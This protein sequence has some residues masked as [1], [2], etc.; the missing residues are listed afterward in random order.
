MKIIQRFI[1]IL[2]FLSFSMQEDHFYEIN[3]DLYTYLDLQGYEN[4]EEYIYILKNLSI[5]FENSYAFNDISKNPPQP[6][7][8]EDYHKRVNITNILNNIN[9]T[10][11][12]AYE[13]YRRIAIALSDLRDAHIQ[14]LFNEFEFKDFFLVS[15]F[16]FYIGEYN[17]QPKIFI[18]CDEAIVSEYSDPFINSMCEGYLSFPVKSINGKDPFDY[19]TD[20]GGHFVSTKNIHGTFSFKMRFH[21]TISLTDFLYDFQDEEMKKINIVLEDNGTEIETIETE[22]RL[23]TDIDIYDESQFLRALKN[24]RGFYTRDFFKKNK[25]KKT[26]NKNWSI[27]EEIKRKNK[28][29]KRNKNKNKNNKIFN[30]NKSKLRN[31]PT[32]WDVDTEIFKCREDNENYLNLYY[33]TSFEPEDRQEFIDSI[34]E[35]VRIFDENTY[36]IV[37]INELNNGGYVSLSQLFMGILSPLMPINLF[38][39][40]IRITESLQESEELINFISSN[41]TDINT[42]QNMTFEQLI[43]GQVT[44]DYSETNLSEVF[45][46]NNASIYRKIENLR[47]NMK[48]K[49][50]PTEILVLTDGYSFSAA[51]LY[52]KYLQKMGG[53]IVAGYYGNPFNRDV[54]DSSQSPSPVFTSK[55][56]N[57]FNPVENGYLFNNYSIELQVPGM[58]TFYELDDK[59]IPLEYDVTPVDYRIDIY[60]DL[61]YNY[62]DYEDHEKEAKIYEAFVNASI[63]IFS[64][65]NETSCDSNKKNIIKFSEECDIYFINSK[66]HGGYICGDDN[67]WSSECIEAFCDEGYIFDKNKKECIKDICSSYYD[68][69]DEEPEEEEE[70]DIDIEEEEEEE[71]EEINEEEESDIEEEEIREEGEEENEE[72]EIKGEEEMEGEEEKINEEEEEEKINDEEEI[73]EEEEIEKEEE[74]INEGQNDKDDKDN[75]DKE[76]KNDYIF[77]VVIGVIGVILIFIFICLLVHYCRKRTSND[78]EIDREIKKI[79]FIEPRPLV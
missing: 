75:K 8:N 15:P 45:Y 69:K 23:F 21:N 78:I 32:F 71:E 34:E 68:E 7:F 25:N 59:N 17:N 72:E 18:D 50:K 35:C 24:G 14:I 1:L 2:Y 60:E 19:I 48:N 56:L 30:E 57:I 63:D 6:D 51:G 39:G 61:N 40:R 52:I 12:N 11:I 73:N 13:F 27:G 26:N 62:N 79:G 58:Q 76:G 5:I 4:E 41:L 44:P 54:F 29:K 22:Y 49:R 36:P 74:E 65:F 66:T 43:E 77:I 37:V 47:L 46:I 9:I 10:D 55:I 70:I 64:K 42:C 3:D 53:A 16:E 20:F 28:L 67:T 33:I 38:K 31:L